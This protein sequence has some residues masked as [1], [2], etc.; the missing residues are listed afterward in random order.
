MSQ[1][2][3]NR[4]AEALMPFGLSQ[5]VEIVNPPLP[6]S[7]SRLSLGPPRLRI[8][9]SPRVVETISSL[10]FDIAHVAGKSIP[11]LTDHAN[12]VLSI[13][14]RTLILQMASSQAL[15]HEASPPY[16]LCVPPSHDPNLPASSS[17]YSSL[18]PGLT[19]HFY[20]HPNAS[21]G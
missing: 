11:S 3:A 4:V 2:D 7:I 17:P 10:R 18:S 19:D 14:I 1:R 16:A 9:D 8:H 12:I 13:D 5:Q 21:A 20:L 15:L 6:V